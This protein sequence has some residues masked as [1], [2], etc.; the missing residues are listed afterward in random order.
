MWTTEKVG[1][2]IDKNG[3]VLCSPFPVVHNHLLCLD[4]VEGK[5]VILAPHGQVFDLLPL[6][7]VSDQAYHH[8]VVN[9][10]AD[11][12]GIVRGPAVGGEQGV[13]EGTKHT[14]L[15][16]PHVEGQRGRGVVTYSYHLSPSGS[17]G[18]SYRGGVQSQG[19]KL[20]DELGRE[21]WC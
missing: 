20:S 21:L 3:G 6:I 5:V 13:Q 8:C 14:A 2:P 9:K 16:G 11:G 19:P 12:V 10:L 1:L 17:I 7:S 18:S 15:R 4:H